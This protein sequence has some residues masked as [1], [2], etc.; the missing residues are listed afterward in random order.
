MS[1]G[2]GGEQATFGGDASPFVEWS[3]P[4]IGW[5]STNK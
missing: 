3:L 4:L 5:A 2:G 1:F